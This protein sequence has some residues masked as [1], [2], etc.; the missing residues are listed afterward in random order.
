MLGIRAKRHVG[1]PKADI[2]TCSSCFIRCT[3]GSVLPTA[4]PAVFA[5]CTHITAI[6]PARPIAQRSPSALPRNSMRCEHCGNFSVAQIVMSA[7]VLQRGRGLSPPRPEGRRVAR[8]FHA[9]GE[10]VVQAA[11]SSFIHAQRKVPKES[12]QSPWT[13]HHR[14]TPQIQSESLPVFG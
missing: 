9:R 4:L 1:P 2:V 3:S 13:P 6:A 10:T 7:E 12:T 5:I 14:I 8:C 11:L